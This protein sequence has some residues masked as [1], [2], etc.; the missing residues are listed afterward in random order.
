MRLA[1]LGQ[2]P[3][4]IPSRPHAIRN[5]VEAECSRR[6]VTLD[7]AL[8]VD[9]ISS[10]LDLVERGLGHAILSLTA[11]LGW[12]K[13]GRVQARK[14]VDPTIVSDLVIATSTQRPLTRLARRAIELIKA[15]IAANV[16]AAPAAAGTRPLIRNA[17]SAC[18]RS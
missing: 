5:L 9:A 11:V 4:I 1:A 12:A 15:E 14:I 3:L 17:K 2:F 16:F 8:E 7:I 13:L 6:G 18:K 10:L